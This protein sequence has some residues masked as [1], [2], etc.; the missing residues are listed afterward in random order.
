MSKNH[1]SESPE[2]PAEEKDLGGIVSH[3]LLAVALMAAQCCIDLDSNLKSANEEYMRGEIPYGAFQYVLQRHTNM[4]AALR[5]AGFTENH[6]IFGWPMRPVSSANA[7]GMA[8]ELAAHDSESPT[9][10]N[11]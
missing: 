2:T 8:R 9:K 10:Q 11:G 6:P 1:T 7:G 4:H 3:D 5:A